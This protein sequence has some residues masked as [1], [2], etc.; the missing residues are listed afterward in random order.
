VDIHSRKLNHDY[1]ITAPQLICLYSLVK[2]GPMTQTELSRKVSMGISTI[3]GVID[4][5]EK[6]HW[7]IRQRDT[8]DRRKVHVA[9]TPA[10]EELT[11]SAPSLLQE[12]F[13]QALM[14]LPESEQAAIAASLERVVEL[15]EAKHLD[16]SPNLVPNN[17]I[18]DKE[19]QSNGH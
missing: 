12:R 10:G 13:S 11:Q 4:R 17:H 1:N 19:N 8:V 14:G 6:K 9:I 7:V 15:M 2:D 16:A 3:N 5:M 18:H